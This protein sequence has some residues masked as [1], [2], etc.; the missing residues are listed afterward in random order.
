MDVSICTDRG[1]IREENED[2]VLMDLEARY[3][4]FFLADG[5]GGYNGGKHAS[6]K[7]VELA[8]ASIKNSFEKDENNIREVLKIAI[9]EANAY[10]YKESVNN[11]NLKGMGTTLII[12]CIYDG[13]LL[14][15][16]VGD[17]RVYLIRNGEI[18]Q[19]TVDHSYVNA[20]IKKGEITEEEAKTHP[21]RNRITRAVGT[22]LTIESDSY[23]IDLLEDD[24]YIISSDGL[25]KMITDRGILNL[26]LK[27]D[28]KC[29]FANE[30][31]EIANKEGG[32]DNIS[33]ITIAINEVEK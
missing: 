10:I 25:T 14:I 1:L 4:L 11:Q 2:F 22:E 32:R 17:S 21:Y 26:Y 9:R 12:A 8:L 13:K 16:H 31:V 6:S 20:L 29:N 3:P 23:E 19:I 15:E 33:V 28:Y 27:N 18:K 24:M 5:M 30:L 7:A